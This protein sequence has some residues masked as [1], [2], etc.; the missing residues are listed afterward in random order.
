MIFKNP[1]FTKKYNNKM[2]ITSLIHR[3]RQQNLARPRSLQTII[4]HRWHRSV[5]VCLRAAVGSIRLLRQPRTPDVPAPIE[6][7]RRMS[8]DRRAHS[9]PP[10]EPTVRGRSGR[11]IQRGTA[12]WGLSSCTAIV[13]IADMDVHLVRQCVYV[14]VL[15]RGQL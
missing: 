1:A 13:R 8:P 7:A 2:T 5:S 15:G 9:A 14:C 11:P 3:H 12:G 6:L 10:T 4:P